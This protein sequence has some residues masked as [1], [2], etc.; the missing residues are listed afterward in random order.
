VFVELL[1]GD[2]W[3]RAA[4]IPRT[5]GGFGGEEAFVTFGAC[6]RGLGGIPAF[7][8]CEG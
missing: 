6:L 4:G 1:F 2:R 3:I 8:S 5:F 7:G